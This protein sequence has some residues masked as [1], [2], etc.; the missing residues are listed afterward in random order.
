MKRFIL[1]TIVPLFF[2]NAAIARDFSAGADL[3]SSYVWRGLHLSGTSIQPSLGF[4]AGNFSIGAWG[5]MPVADFQSYKEFDLS[6]SYQ[7]AGFSIGINDYWIPN[8]SSSYFN[9]DKN[10]GTAHTFEAS[11][12]YTLPIEKFPLSLSWNT[13]FAG[14]DGTKSNGKTAWSSYFE[15][16]YPF[17]VKEVALS[18]SLGLSPWET[19]YYNAPGFSVINIS[20]KATK[21]IK[22][23]GFA[24][25]VWVQTILNPRAENVFLVL[26]ISL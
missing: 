18:A 8:D 7:V 1:L 15:L 9:Y 20:L 11:V 13:N 3:V 14:F 4:S 5:S 10:K 21:E 17:T 2:V 6:I 26:G 12:G 16:S 22:L 19:D 23:G 25:P 24:L